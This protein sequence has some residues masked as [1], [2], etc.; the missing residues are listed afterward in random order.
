MKHGVSSYSF[1]SLLCSH[2]MDLYEVV[3]KAAEL[4]FEGLELANITDAWMGIEVDLPKLKETA[5]QAHIALCSWAASADYSGA[6]PQKEVARIKKQVDDAAFLG[7]KVF[8][9]DVCA[10]GTVDRY[11]QQIIDAVREVAQYCET[12]GILLV[13]ENHGRCYCRPER[14]EELCRLVKHQN[15][16]LL[17][18]FA[19][20]E[21][22]DVHALDAVGQIRTLVRH[23]HMKDCHLLSGDRVFP[24]EGWHTT[25]SGN[26]W[27]CAIT[28]QGNIPYYQ[29]MKSL[30]EV[31]YD[32]WLVQE[33]EGIED[34][35]YAVE[36][37][38]AFTKRLLAALTYGMRKENQ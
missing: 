25:I 20:Y 36:Q 24:G 7:C 19:N 1:A 22:A 35:I 33:F 14:L 27:R 28:G 31:G 3:Q 18:D 2:K 23:V 34:C 21:I 10:E 38:L 37:G 30:Q 6:E 29:C 17:C 8:R 4:G 13:T 9:T 11:D 16:G 26:Y 32:G 12:K 15:F 5:E